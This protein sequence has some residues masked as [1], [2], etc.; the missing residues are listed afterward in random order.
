MRL[1]DV[2]GRFCCCCKRQ[3]AASEAASQDRSTLDVT[4]RSSIGQRL[5]YSTVE[6]SS[7]L[8]RFTDEG[9]RASIPLQATDRV[10]IR[11]KHLGYG[12][13]DTTLVLQPGQTRHQLVVTLDPVVFRIA[14]VSVKGKSSC[15]V[16]A[17]SA[18][19]IGRLVGE[20][21]KEKCGTRKPFLLR[22]HYPFSYR[23]AR[24]FEIGTSF[25]TGF[26]HDTVEF[27]SAATLSYEP[28]KLI[29]SS[30]LRR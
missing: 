15:R 18:S 11:I 1:Q 10:R 30:T 8:S 29:R 28:G 12:A 14:T 20:L 13:I 27:Q 17:D 6:V 16:I 7:G 9:G 21:Q 2:V 4:V 25:S 22:N 26:R 19:Q 3:A 24:K 5:G 23:L